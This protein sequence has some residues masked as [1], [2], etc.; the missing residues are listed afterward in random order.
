MSSFKRPFCDRGRRCHRFSHRVRAV[1]NRSRQADWCR[2]RGRLPTPNDV[3]P[4]LLRRERVGVAA[5]LRN[6]DPLDL[7]RVALGRG[8]KVRVRNVAHA[9]HLKAAAFLQRAGSRPALRSRCTSSSHRSARP[10]RRCSGRRNACR[11]GGA[12]RGRPSPR[13][14]RSC[15]RSCCGRLV[16][17]RYGGLASHGFW[18]H[19]SVVEAT[20][21]VRY[22]AVLAAPCATRG[23]RHTR[24]L[25]QVP[26]LRRQS[27]G[28][29]L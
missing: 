28:H 9:Q 6:G 19:R 4:E 5:R 18:P 12:A 29:P 23:R 1:S 3:A 26:R 24:Q 27:H 21:R 20:E 14:R 2:P 22:D 10:R 17:L 25:P 8:A 15:P 16:R 11:P 13:C 7:V